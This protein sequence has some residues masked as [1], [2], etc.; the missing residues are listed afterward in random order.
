MNRDTIEYLYKSGKM[1]TRY[2]NQLNGKNA[3]E[4]YNTYLREKNI[5]S[6]SCLLDKAELQKI[7]ESA[8]DD[9]VKSLSGAK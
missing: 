8:I 1:P 9:I 3:Q 5:N 6:Q 4:N 7:I 2:Y